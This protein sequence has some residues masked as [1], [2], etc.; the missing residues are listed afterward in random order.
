MHIRSIQC[1]SSGPRV[2]GAGS[3]W[4]A[5]S[6][7]RPPA[8]PAFRSSWGAA[9][10]ERPSAELAF[11]SSRC[12]APPLCLMGF[13]D[14]PALEAKMQIKSRF[15]PPGSGPESAQNLR[16][17]KAGP[18][19]GPP[20]GGETRAKTKAFLN[21]AGK[22]PTLSDGFRV[23]AAWPNNFQAFIPQLGRGRL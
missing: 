4:H 20:G 13:Q 5:A 14:P 6:P 12:K 7:E 1:R 19:P 18:S 23:G 8:M 15:P 17:P 11:R 9:S 21:T 22:P 3:S 2:C 10:S 16:S